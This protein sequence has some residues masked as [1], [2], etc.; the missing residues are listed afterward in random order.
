MALPRNAQD[1]SQVHPRVQR[2][3]TF[4]ANVLRRG[5]WVHHERDTRAGFFTSITSA[6]LREIELG[7]RADYHVAQ[8]NGYSVNADALTRILNYNSTR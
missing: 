3:A 5:A 2:E 4:T 1:P 8:Q 7:R 6:T